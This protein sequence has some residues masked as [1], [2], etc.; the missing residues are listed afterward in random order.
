[1]NVELFSGIVAILI[2]LSCSYV[3]GVSGKWAGLSGEWKR[4]L[5][6]AA[7]LIVA[8]ASVALSC[9]NVIDLVTCDKRGIFA[10]ISAFI[11]ALIANQ[12]VYQITRG[13]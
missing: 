11:S 5:M 3:P 4:L 10:V 6:A 2:S 8:V 9:A 1:M 12:S 7:M 13:S